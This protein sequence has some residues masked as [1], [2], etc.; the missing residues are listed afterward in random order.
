MAK[1]SRRYLNLAKDLQFELT[2]VHLAFY[3]SRP[4]C[5]LT[6]AFLVVEHGEVLPTNSCMHPNY[7]AIT[8]SRVSR[9]GGGYPSLAKGPKFN[10]TSFKYAL[11]SYRGNDLSYDNYMQSTIYQHS[12]G[13]G[14]VIKRVAQFLYHA[15]SGSIDLDQLEMVVEEIFT[16]LEEMPAKAYPFYSMMNS[17]KS[18]SSW[19]YCILFSVPPSSHLSP[20]LCSLVTTIKVTEDTR[21]FFWWDIFLLIK[22][23]YCV[24]IDA[25]RLVVHEGFRAPAS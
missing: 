16:N 14:M 4:E 23:N 22:K 8:S 13:I 2:Q 18:D 20:Y 19:E 7:H 11:D 17:R 24:Q 5:P 3:L 15:L 10:W 25:L 6:A 12:Q 21:N 9:L 1:F